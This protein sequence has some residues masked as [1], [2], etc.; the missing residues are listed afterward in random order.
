M[1]ADEFFAH[2]ALLTFDFLMVLGVIRVVK[3][4]LYLVENL[5]WMGVD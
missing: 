2:I 4:I 5:Q 3:G 1:R